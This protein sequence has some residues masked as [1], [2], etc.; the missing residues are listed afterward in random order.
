MYIPNQAHRE[1]I[2]VG[3]V[4]QLELMALGITLAVPAFVVLNVWSTQLR[5]RESLRAATWRIAPWA[6]GITALALYA[7]PVVADY[8]GDPLSHAS[9]A[10]WLPARLLELAIWSTVLWA[11]WQYTAMWLYPLAARVE[12]ARI[13]D[14]YI[15]GTKIESG[16]PAQQHAAKWLTTHARRNDGTKL[17]STLCCGMFVPKGDEVKHFL[18]VALTGAGKSQAMRG[19]AKTVV[20]RSRHSRERMFCL[21][22]DGAMVARFL[23]PKRDKILNIFDKRSVNWALFRDIRSPED[24]A[25]FAAAIVPEPVSASAQEWATMARIIVR[26]AIDELHKMGGAETRDLYEVCCL[27]T[28]DELEKFLNNS[29]AKRYFGRAEETRDSILTTLSTYLAPFRFIERGD[30]FSITEWIEHGTGN[31]F[32]PYKSKQIDALQAL[33]RTWTRIGLTAAESLPESRETKL[34]FFIDE[35]DA[36]GKLDGIAGALKRLRKHGVSVSFGTQTI[37]M[38]DQ[39]Y[40]RGYADSIRENAGNIIVMKCGGGERGTAGWASQ[41]IGKYDVLRRLHNTSTSAGNSFGSLG[42]LHTQNRA[43]STSINE[44]IADKWAVLPTEIGQLPD[45]SAYVK[46]ASAEEWRKVNVPLDGL[47]KI[48]AEFEPKPWTTHKP[49]VAAPELAED[50]AHS[51][52]K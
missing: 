41:I 30:N 4:H 43:T 9:G 27:S 17:N 14:V 1:S 25:F 5:G 46:F 3:A 37:S 50:A 51:A 49:D 15:R 19:Q 31:L 11:I 13:D 28:V 48:A 52:T 10:V 32:L 47:A 21:D 35:F 24:S 7:L 6:G 36:L 20:E 18:Y 42:G 34:S 23:D 8:Y 33:Y 39:D 22:P 16:T 40:G 29:E 26:C 38:L 2:P 44:Q 12:H 45:L